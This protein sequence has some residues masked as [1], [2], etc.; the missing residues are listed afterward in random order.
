MDSPPPVVD[1]LIHVMDGF[2]HTGLDYADR[3]E[4]ELAGAG[5]STAR[6]ELPRGNDGR[7]PSARAHI[8]TGGETS[9]TADVSWIRS[10]IESARSLMAGAVAGKWSVIG[11]CLGAQVLAEALRPSSIA[12]SGSIEVGLI[13]I[14]QVSGSGE[15][16]VPLFHYESISEDLLSTPGV[17]VT[18][19]NAHTPVQAFRYGDRVFGYQ[20]HPELTAPDL[21]E[22]ID[23]HAD[24]ISRS[25][26]NVMDA[27]RSVERHADHLSGDLFRRTVLEQLRL[28]HE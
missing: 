24:L 5:F 27:H 18:Y 12:S 11:I 13:P 10:A 15:L 9:A 25:H 3:V 22:L 7:Q 20:F 21:H 8:F 4:E 28:R 2:V 14:T 23:H 1:V 6:Q 17:K 19:R 26:G 16:I